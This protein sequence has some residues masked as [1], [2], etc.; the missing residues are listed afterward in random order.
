MGG[1]EWDPTD[2]DAWR[3]GLPYALE[4]REREGHALIPAKY[5]AND[6]FPLG[7]W[8]NKLR[9]KYGQ[10][11]LSAEQI[12]AIEEAV[13][14]WK[15]KDPQRKGPWTPAE[16]KIIAQDKVSMQELCR[17]VPSRSR[18]S[19]SDRRRTLHGVERPKAKPWTPK[20]DKIVRQNGVSMEELSRRLGRTNSAIRQRRSV[21]GAPVGGAAQTYTHAWEPR[22]G[23]QRLTHG[24]VTRAKFVC[25]K[26]NSQS[27]AGIL[28]LTVAAR[29]SA[30]RVGRRGAVTALPYSN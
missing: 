1:W 29:Q 11:K 17:L 20:E 23:A 21:R 19:L 2:H 4:F 30:V 24:N 27:L 26:G 9:T 12:Q 6:G 14:G 15:W 22:A 10:D 16:D 7:R 5:K 25:R 8:T 13:D 3:K 28:A 18:R